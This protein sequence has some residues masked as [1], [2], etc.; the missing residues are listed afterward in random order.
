MSELVFDL[1]KITVQQISDYLDAARET[2]VDGMAK[3][4]A[5]TC[6][7]VPHDWGNASDSTTFADLTW[8]DLN[9]AN[10]AFNEAAKEA[11]DFEAAEFAI[12]HDLSRVKAKAFSAEFLKPLRSND[13]ETVIKFLAKSLTS[14]P[15]E[16]GRPD[17][18][19]TYWD[20][21]YYTVF[22]PLCQQVAN[23]ARGQNEKKS[24][25]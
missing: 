14:V 16:W 19:S 8:Y 2:D 3:A 5:L 4:F 11:K 7:N 15:A 6:V 21:P 25:R 20:L 10:D 23:E 18:P 9:A 24:R 22:I 12:Q 13:N 1:S 17:K